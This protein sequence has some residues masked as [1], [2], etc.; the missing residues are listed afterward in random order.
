[1]RSL[2]V[3]RNEKFRMTARLG[4]G[5]EKQPSRSRAHPLGLLVLGAVAVALSLWLHPFS[6]GA[7]FRSQPIIVLGS[8]TGLA[9]PAAEAAFSRLG[10]LPP[11][12]AGVLAIAL[13]ASA[14]AAALWLWIRL[15]YRGSRLPTRIALLLFGASF[16]PFYAGL[17]QGSA[18]WLL[19]LLLGLSFDLRERGRTKRAAFLLA[20]AIHLFVAP[21]IVA[22][23]AGRTR[24][25]AYSLHAL[26]FTALLA[27]LAVWAASP[28][29]YGAYAARLG[30][31]PVRAF[32]TL[33][34]LPP[35]AA[36]ALPAI[37]LALLAVLTLEC[38][39]LAGRT[40]ARL[41]R[42]LLVLPLLLL[43]P[44]FGP[45]GSL[46]TLPLFLTWVGTFAEKYHEAP[47]ALRIGPAELWGLSCFF[48]AIL[49]SA[50]APAMSVP[51]LLMALAVL[52]RKLRRTQRRKTIPIADYRLNRS[53]RLRAR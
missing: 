53:R 26:L 48:L 13:A 6:P 43:L 17:R 21:L 32:W 24:R 5:G 2:K 31:E 25:D 52:V 23:F 14:Y 28:A 9:V 45:A 8:G 38:R 4:G 15:A 30:L 3:Y 47:A 27:P 40:G 37:S 49:L 29:A 18:D 42:T 1:M 41:R 39:R 50:A 16:A 46:M 44:A 34:G 11:R 22:L 36:L 12:Q 20:M 7:L 19:L 10:L 51:L 33:P 35:A